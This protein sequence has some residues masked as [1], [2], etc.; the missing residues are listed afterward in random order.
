ML[1]PKF[2]FIRPPYCMTFCFLFCC[3]SKALLI[4]ENSLG[5]TKS[6]QLQATLTT[7]LDSNSAKNTLDTN[8][9]LYSFERDFW[10]TNLYA[11]LYKYS[12]PKCY[13]KNFL[14]IDPQLCDF[15]FL[16]CCSSKALL[17]L[18]NSLG[19]TKSTQLKA[20]LTT[21]LDSNSAKNTSD[22]N[23]I[24]YIWKGFLSWFICRSLQVRQ[25]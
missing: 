21:H 3:S 7:H 9:I 11:G 20:T 12:R 4:L 14:L 13:P 19:S 22:T 2:P 23:T 6:T 8:I 25:A 17:I 24:L 1:S 5:S 10:A 18:E 16:F 15:L